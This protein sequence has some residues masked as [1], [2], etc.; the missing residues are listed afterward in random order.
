MVCTAN[1]A[2]SIWLPLHCTARFVS[3]LLQVTVA[4]RYLKK[5]Y[6]FPEMATRAAAAAA[7]AAAR[8]QWHQQLLLQRYDAFKS[9]FPQQRAHIDSLVQQM[10]ECVQLLSEQPREQPPAP[11]PAS[12]LQEH[13]AAADAQQQQQ[14]VQSAAA[15][16]GPQQQGQQQQQQQND[17]EGQGTGVDAGAA[18]AEEEEESPDEQWE[19]V[20]AGGTSA[21][22]GAAA[23]L[24][25]DMDDD[26]V[27]D[28]P[29]PT[30]A[31]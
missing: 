30:S 22:E 9:D 12:A 23:M 8:L 26:L 14:S 15:S 18:A 16:P 21:P 5:Q 11:A 13:A 7:A 19:D 4:Y 2:T 31:G 6:K 20:P 10:Q 3:P 17:K 24:V 29:D 27:G 28:Y 1:R 25:W